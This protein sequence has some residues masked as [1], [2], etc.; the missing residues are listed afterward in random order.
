M[1][2]A[3]I[4]EEYQEW[5]KTVPMLYETVVTRTLAWPT[6]TCQWLPGQTIKDGASY[7]ELMIGTN[8]SDQEPNA[9]LFQTVTLPQNNQS[10]VKA[11]ITPKQSIGHENEVN[12]ARCQPNHPSIIAT[13]TRDGDVLVFDRQLSLSAASTTNLESE[14][15]LRLKGHSGEGYGLQWN[16]HS[17]KENHLLSAGY[18]KVVCHWDIGQTPDGKEL[19]PYQTYVGHTDCVEDVSWSTSNVSLFASVGDDRKLMIWDTRQPT[20]AVQ[21]IQAH[22]AEINSVRFH[23]TRETMLATGSA[24]KTIGLFDIRKLSDKL[25]SIEHSSAVGQVEWSPLDDPI[26]GSAAGRQI[27]IWDLRRIGEEQTA[28]DAEDGPAELMFVH[29]GHTDIVTEFG[30]HPTEQWL[31][32]SAAQDNNIQVWQMSKAICSN[33]DSTALVGVEFE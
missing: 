1:D 24:D 27:N 10:T 2:K 5:K 22:E 13:M 23:P 15:I 18:D 33:A 17:V 4:A 12:R 25:H 11:S 7:Q 31:I 21:C 26:I 32:A 6:L 8:T 3:K 29:N 20:K 28:E 14:P 16:P 19:R 30:W 9:L